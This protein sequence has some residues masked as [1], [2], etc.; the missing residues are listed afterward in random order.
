MKAAKLTWGAWFALLISL[1]IFGLSACGSDDEEQPKTTLE[2]NVQELFFEGKSGAS[3]R[4]AISSNAN[5]E[6]TQMPDWLW[7]NATNGTGN[8]N[9]DF[10]TT[11]AN[12]DMAER[13]SIVVIEA[14]GKTV[15]ITVTQAKAETT[16]EADLTELEFEGTSTLWKYVT[17]TSNRAWEVTS[18][19]EWIDMNLK[20]GEGVTEVRISPTSTNSELTTREGE[21][22]I[23]SDDKTISITVRQKSQYADCSATVENAIIMSDN[24]YADLAF[25][26]NTVSYAEAYFNASSVKNATD[27]YLYNKVKAETPYDVKYDYTINWDIPEET[28]V[29]YCVI[30]I[31]TVNGKEAY[32]PMTKFSFTTKS[33]STSSDALISTL[34]YTSTKWRYIVNK[35]TDCAY[36]YTAYFT[37]DLAEAINADDYTSA[38]IAYLLKGS[39]GNGLQ[40]D[41]EGGLKELS[42]EE[43]TGLCVCT[44]GVSSQGEF[45]G[46]LQSAYKSI[47]ATS[48]HRQAASKGVKN[49][50]GMR[51]GKK[52][53]R[54]Q[55]EAHKK[56]LH[57]VKVTQ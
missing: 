1:S 44:W 8:R 52:L 56:K 40:P 26:S 17:I 42:R 22:V 36:Y 29:L 53:T 13:S 5:W 48:S 49:A 33:A 51:P 12:M 14:E 31:T 45:S 38:F 34:A 9:V 54:Q 46:N 3:Q 21:I 37:D 55:I 4:L 10:Y 19:P 24:F 41:T 28:E 2:V 6:I 23:T 35:Q 32:G 47:S 20:S 50:N 15:T 57:L 18:C 39:I 7:A 11:M 30:P 25:S 27:Q 16:L 43:E